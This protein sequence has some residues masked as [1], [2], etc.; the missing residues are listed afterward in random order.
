MFMRQERIALLLLVGV[1]VVVITANSALTLIGKEPFARPFSG[2]SPDGELVVIE[3]TVSRVNL[4][5]NGGH[6]TL[7]VANT[8]IFVPAPVAQGRVIH[9]NDTV[10]AF[11]IVETYRGNKEI[12][13]S[14]TDDLRITTHP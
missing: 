4:I 7:L 10:R 8:T 1:A 6:L 12:V 3:G 14:N 9:R 11:G 13:V 5:E 2:D